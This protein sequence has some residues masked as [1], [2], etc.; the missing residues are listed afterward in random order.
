MISKDSSLDEIKDV[1]KHCLDKVHSEHGKIFE[2]NKRRGVCERAITFRFAHYLQN[3][4][5][6]WFVDCDYNSSFKNG[7]ERTGKPI[8]NRDGSITFR[9]P[10]IIVHKRNEQPY[11]DLICF[12]IKKWNNYDKEGIEKDINNLVE[13]TSVY[14]Y[15]YGF[16]ITIH[17]KKEKTRWTI[18]KR[19][20]DIEQNRLV[21][22]NNPQVL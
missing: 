21:F 10:D 11:T 5:R 12:E 15:A 7:Q 3:K 1:V 13:L 20:T 9:F 19:G 4:L 17:R 22:D 16:Y 18:F 14:G 2:K 6:G 8:E